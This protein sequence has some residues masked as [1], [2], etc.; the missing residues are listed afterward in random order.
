MN[1][2]AIR[3]SLYT[4]TIIVAMFVP[5]PVTV[6]LAACAGICIGARIERSYAETRDANHEWQ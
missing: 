1:T 3:L 6:A 2:N 5:N 4:T